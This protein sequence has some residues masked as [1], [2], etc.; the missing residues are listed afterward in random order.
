MVMASRVASASKPASSDGTKDKNTAQDGGADAK[1]EMTPEQKMQAR[2]P[3]PAKV[4]HLIGLPVLDGNDS[5]Q[6]LW[7]RAGYRRQGEWSRWV[8]P[9]R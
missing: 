2:F 8:K 3:Q 5:A 9:L 6:G 1:P 4:G 7:S